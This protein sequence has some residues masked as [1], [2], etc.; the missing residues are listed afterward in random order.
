LETIAMHRNRPGDIMSCDPDRGSWPPRLAQEA[1]LRQLEGRLCDDGAPIDLL[2]ERAGLLAALGRPQ[3][4]RQSYLDAIRRAPDHFGAL[5]D[6]GTLLYA[7][8]YRAAARTAYLE[9]VAR[10]PDEPMGHVNLGNLLLGAGEI[11]TA[12]Q[13]FEAALRLDRDHA[14]AHR[15]LALALAELGDHRRADRHRRRGFQ[16]RF[17]T[18][19]PYRGTSPPLPLLVLVSARGGNIPIGSFVDD[20]IF[21]SSVLVAEYDDPAVP[22]PPHRL[23]FNTIGDADLCRPALRAAASLLARTSAPVVNHP[24]S[25]LRTGRVANARRLSALPGVRTPRI[26]ELPHAALIAPDAPAAVARHGLAFPLLLRSP[27]FHTGR[28]FVLVETAADLA[29]AASSLPAGRV[30]LIEHLNARGPDGNA[31]K[32]RVMVIDGR[33]HPLH[34][35]ISR[36]WKVHYFTADMAE[37]PQHRAEDGAFLDDMA[38]AIGHRAMAALERIR[39][40][41][42][43]DYGGIDFGLSPD[44]DVLLF[45][46]NATMVVNPPDADERWAYRQPAVARILDA[47]RG[48]IMRRASSG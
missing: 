16:G 22:L 29:A 44:G 20:R 40:D 6:F 7:T 14:Q 28:H 37:Y 47:A 30:L 5:N 18:T 8:G 35:A 9:A 19:L 36:H 10:H 43:L 24:S 33:I 15:G 38:A 32:Y 26:I 27:G 13:H 12:R 45:E 39:D 11:T 21:L 48:M 46:A 25:V 34:V 42:D 3:D 41:L 31:R 1:R 17:V 4:A 23:V 2:V